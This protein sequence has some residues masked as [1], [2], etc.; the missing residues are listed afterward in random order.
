MRQASPLPPL[1]GEK[2]VPI[3]GA[4]SLEHD[5]DG[6]AELLGEDGQRLGL[7]V[8]V[9]ESLMEL[10]AIGIGSQEQASGLAEGP[11]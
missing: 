9:H 8:L 5:V 7:A 6:A 10:L 1:S 11:S 3:E 2:R 4:L